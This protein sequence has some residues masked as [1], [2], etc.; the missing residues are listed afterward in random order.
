MDG[1]ERW[2]AETIPLRGQVIA[3]VGANVGR[4]SQFFWEASGGSSRVVSIEPLPENVSAIR[5][6]IRA[7]GAGNWTVEACAVSAS[8]GSL[9]LAAA[10]AAGGRWN[11]VVSHGRASHTV[12]CRTL[13]AMVP[14]ATVVKLD[15]EGHEY[16][17]LDEALPRMAQVHTWALELHKVQ[18]RAL[19][20][21]RG[22]LAAHGYRLQAA[23]R[24]AGPSS[25]RWI[26]AEIAPTL[27]WD[28]V[29]AGRAGANGR[30]FQ[31]RHVIAQRRTA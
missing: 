31:M 17:V 14:D 23:A 3:D 5:E 2:Y 27:G 13:S 9:E 20:A 30:P 11:S 1:Q 6:R 19:P 15:I 10:R 18:G 29:P 26:S 16:A 25:G 4:L 24:V 21:T 12:P 28:A 7:A 8:S 22:A